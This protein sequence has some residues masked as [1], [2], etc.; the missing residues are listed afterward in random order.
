[1]FIGAVLSSLLGLASGVPPCFFKHSKS[2]MFSMMY[3]G[4]WP[5]CRLFQIIFK[6]FVSLL[7]FYDLLDGK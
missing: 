4:S 5:F 6:F 1:M 3:L 2:I 7:I